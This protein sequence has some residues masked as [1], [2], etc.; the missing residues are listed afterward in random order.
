MVLPI[1]ILT[2]TLTEAEIA[3]LIA[4]RIQR[5]REDRFLRD[6]EEQRERVKINE[7]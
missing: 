2:D 7:E 5:D 1:D 3:A 6:I 4:E